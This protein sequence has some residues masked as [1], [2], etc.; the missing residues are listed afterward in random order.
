MIH[1]VMESILEEDSPL[2]RGDEE[3]KSGG[4]AISH[5]HS[6]SHSASTSE[7]AEVEVEEDELEAMKRKVK[8]MQ[9]EAERLEQIQ[10]Q[11]E[12]SMN[13]TT[14]LRDSK[15]V[16]KRSIYVGNVDYGAT[17][18]ELQSHFQ[19]CGTINRVTILCDKYSGHPKGYAYIEF[20]EEDSINNAMV[21]NESLFRGRLL[22]VVPKRTNVPGLGR[23]SAYPPF[24]LPP[25]RYRA[26]RGRF[27]RAR[28]KRAYYHP[29]M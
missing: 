10:K 29:Y 21:M 3:H 13:P 28:S 7:D 6:H 5:S 15:D 8:E 14:G 9:E 16:D 2:R 25:P 27:Y 20:L 4:Q 22:K 12:E 18:E 24:M 17:P 26:Y 11:V 23:A 1:M 19:S